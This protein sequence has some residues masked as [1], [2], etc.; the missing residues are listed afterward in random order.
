[1]DLIIVAAGVGS[2]LNKGVPKAILPINGKPNLTR[3]LEMASPFFEKIYVVINKMAHKSWDNYSKGLSKFF[4]S[5]NEKVKFVSIE[6]GLG[7]GHALL[8]ALNCISSFGKIDSNV[9]VCWGDAVFKDNFIFSELSEM[10]HSVGLI[11]VV[12]EKDPYVTILTDTELN[13]IAID[14]AKQGERHPTGFHDQSIFKFNTEI[15]LNGLTTL[16]NSLF[17][18][19]RYI[20]SNSELHVLYLTHYLNNIGTPLRVYETANS[21]LSYN[22]QEELSEVQEILKEEA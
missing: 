16:H 14:S 11:P 19:G 9:V 17:K 10:N 15:L 5:I 12:K 13:A 20:T 4:P 3:T 21:I 2:R 6:S 22:T 8:M 7:D 18:G 1:M